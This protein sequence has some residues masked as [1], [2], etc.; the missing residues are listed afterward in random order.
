[1]KVICKFYTLINK[2]LTRREMNT[3][4]SQFLEL[5]PISAVDR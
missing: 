3:F 1:M 4:N 5:A 2:G